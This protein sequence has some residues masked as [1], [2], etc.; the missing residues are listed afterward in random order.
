MARPKFS[1]NMIW[2]LRV[3]FIL[4]LSS[5]LLVTSWASAHVALWDIPP[6]VASHPWFIASLFDAY[7]GFL[8]FYIWIAYKENSIPARALWLVAVL[9]LG[10][11][12][13]ATYMLIQLFRLPSTSSIKELILKK[14]TR[15]VI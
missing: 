5:M 2:F 3:V 6:D 10:N 8:T 15:G 11:I 13:M 7:F 4:I 9:V 12:A 1:S 14:S